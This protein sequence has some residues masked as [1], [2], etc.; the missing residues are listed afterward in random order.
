[1]TLATQFQKSLSRENITQIKIHL[2]FDILPV[3]RNMANLALDA[4]PAVMNVIRGMA[5]KTGPRRLDRLGFCF[6][7]TIFALDLGML[8]G[9]HEARRRMIEIPGF[10]R[11]GGVAGFALLAVAAFVLVVLLVTTVTAQRRVLEGWR[12]VTLFAFNLGVTAGQC[13]ARLVVI[14]GRVLPFLF[15]VATLTFVA[16][17]AFVLVILLVASNA[18]LF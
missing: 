4:E 2:P 11:T 6:L 5:R 16:E 15:V 13:E 1:M 12:Q 3:R 7:V 8:A 18:G 10:P 17:L 9:Q 14:E